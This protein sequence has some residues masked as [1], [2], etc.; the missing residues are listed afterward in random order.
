MTITFGIIHAA[1]FTVKSSETLKGDKI[2]LEHPKITIVNRDTIRQQNS[3]LF[4]IE[5]SKHHKDKLLCKS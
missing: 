3:H 5:Y 2:N 1:S 4:H